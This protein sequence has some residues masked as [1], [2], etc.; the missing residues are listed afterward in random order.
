MNGGEVPDKFVLYQNYPNPFNPYSTIAFDLPEHGDVTLKIYNLLGE[1]VA[2]L[3]DHSLPA[4]KYKFRWE[5][6][7][8]SSGV[9]VYVIQ[10]NN[11]RSKRKMVLVK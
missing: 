6:N 11:F 4:G 3:V 5:P 1:N 2:T 7:G 10:A 9:Y 8:L